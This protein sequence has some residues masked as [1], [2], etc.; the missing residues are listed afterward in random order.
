MVYI[1]YICSQ[2]IIFF[3]EAAKAR[4]K[5]WLPMS[6]L[7]QARLLAK[8]NFKFKV[9]FCVPY[10]LC[11]FYKVCVIMLVSNSTFGITCAIIYINSILDSFVL[12]KIYIIF[13]Q[14][15]LLPP[16]GK[17]TSMISELILMIIHVWFDCSMAGVRRPSIS[18]LTQISHMYWW[19]GGRP[20]S[21]AD[22]SS[23]AL[24]WTVLGIWVSDMCQLYWLPW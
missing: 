2:L 5:R 24:P 22:T 8:L 13:G 6:H 10:S 7:S 15:C 11:H 12:A 23:N 9:C 21:D 16:L 1:I 19:W 20:R 18:F 4:R 3:K 17:R 14:A